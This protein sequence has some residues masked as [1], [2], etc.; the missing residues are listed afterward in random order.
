[1]NV[2]VKLKKYY[3]KSILGDMF[4]RLKRNPKLIAYIILLDLLFLGC[5][6]LLNY[7]IEKYF[8]GKNFT[9]LTLISL[10]YFLLLIF[11]HSFFNF[12]ILGNIKKLLFDYKHDFSLLKKL[13]ILNVLFFIIF[14]LLIAFLTYLYGFLLQKPIWLAVIILILLILMFIFFYVFYNFGSSLLM[15]NFK[16][17][18]SLSL[19]LKYVFS[20]KYFGLLLLNIV[21]IGLYFII[22]ISLV[23]LF[24]SFNL[25]SE[26]LINIFTIMLF[27]L[28]YGLFFINRIYFFFI[29][30]KSIG[31]KTN[32]KSN[33]SKLKNLQNKNR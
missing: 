12:L 29:T 3:K 30:E 11:A 22:Y 5:I 9:I 33:N 28:F 21:L 10:I 13:F 20:K 2:V 18:N 19:A 6:Y 15:L 24:D 1:M 14:F 23:F 7:F 31:N 32:N 4:V 17:K 25:S 16:I 8:L 27:L 26:L